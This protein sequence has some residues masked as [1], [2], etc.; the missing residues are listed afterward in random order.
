MSAKFK[1]VDRKD[2]FFT[3]KLSMQKKLDDSFEDYQKDF[4]EGA[5]IS[6]FQADKEVAKNHL[7]TPITASI[8]SKSMA[9]V[10][11][12]TLDDLLL[13]QSSTTG[14]WSDIS[15]IMSFFS[16]SSEVDAKKADALVNVTDVAQHGAVWATL[17]ALY[18]LQKK[19]EDKESEW[20][21]IATK[22]KN[23]LKSQGIP[24]ADSIIKTFKFAL[25]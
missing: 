17:L 7:F 23:F 18:I 9:P 24:K 4:D 19:F 5:Q 10:K 12:K 21:L 22:A 8:S 11:P 20:Q 25:N 1:A 6:L 14:S 2:N 3:E 13:A 15:L 16:N